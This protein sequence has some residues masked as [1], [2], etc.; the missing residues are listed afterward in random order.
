MARKKQAVEREETEKSNPDNLDRNSAAG[1]DFVG[2][3]IEGK[4]VLRVLST[5][6]GEEETVHVVLMEDGEKKTLPVGF[7]EFDTPEEE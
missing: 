3:F 6:V 4:E 2:K 7:D 1:E 5:S